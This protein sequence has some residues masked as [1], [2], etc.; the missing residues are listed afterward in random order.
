[1]YRIFCHFV[2]EFIRKRHREARLQRA[3]ADIG[4][5]QIGGTQRN[6]KRQQ[7]GAPR[8]IGKTHHIA[9][10][11]TLLALDITQ[12]GEQT[13]GFEFRPPHVLRALWVSAISL[14]VV[15]AL[16]LA[17]LR[18]TGAEPGESSAENG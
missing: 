18:R 12:A 5:S 4:K 2:F 10:N 8:T 1:M 14:A 11:R 6:R 15:L 3:Q 17:T 7:I 9:T 13:I 16:L